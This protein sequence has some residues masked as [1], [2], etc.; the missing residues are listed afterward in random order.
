MQLREFIRLDNKGCST[1][2]DERP[3]STVA[4]DLEIAYHT[5]AKSA[6]GKSWREQLM[7]AQVQRGLPHRIF[8]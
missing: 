3:K 4:L 1:T 6:K 5:E 7:T 8:S 2:T